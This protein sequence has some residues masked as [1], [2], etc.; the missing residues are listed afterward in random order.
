MNPGYHNGGDQFK[1]MP[2]YQP[3]SYDENFSDDN[4]SPVRPGFIQTQQ[5]APLRD[6]RN[7]GLKKGE[8]RQPRF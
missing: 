6:E 5:T 3:F 1:P 4:Q 2:Q 7:R 8:R